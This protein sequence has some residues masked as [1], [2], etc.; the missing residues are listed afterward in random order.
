M[1]NTKVATVDKHGVISARGE[2]ETTVTVSTSNGL[3]KELTVVVDDHTQPHRIVILNG[4]SLEAL[5]S[6]DYMNLNCVVYDEDNNLISKP[7]LQWTTDDKSIATVKKGRVTFK[8]EGT[9]TITAALKKHP[10]IAPAS[11]TITIK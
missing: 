5:R 7:S 8:S 4:A 10:D 9:V 2:G 6:D 3:K 11:I 1:K